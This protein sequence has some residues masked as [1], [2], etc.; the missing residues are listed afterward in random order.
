MQAFDAHVKKVLNSEKMKEVA[1]SAQPFFKDV[2]DFV[3]GRPTTMEN[4][5]SLMCYLLASAMTYSVFL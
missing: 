5:V 1:Q 4:M 3:F 2:R